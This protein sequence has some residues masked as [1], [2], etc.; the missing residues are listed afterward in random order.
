MNNSFEHPFNLWRSPVLIEKKH[1]KMTDSY[2]LIL[3]KLDRNSGAFQAK[4]KKIIV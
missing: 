4:T 3:I 1:P 2:S